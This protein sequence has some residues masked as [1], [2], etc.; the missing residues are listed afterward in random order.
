MFFD[1][2]LGWERWVGGIEVK[3]R[4]GLGNRSGERT[5]TGCREEGCVGITCLWEQRNE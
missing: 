5:G 4:I 3:G 1:L 2:W